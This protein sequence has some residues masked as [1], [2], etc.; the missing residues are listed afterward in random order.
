L[1]KSVDNHVELRIIRKLVDISYRVSEQ[2]AALGKTCPVWS[3]DQ[4]FTP[5]LNNA[6]PLIDDLLGNPIA[7]IHQFPNNPQ[8]DMIVHRFCQAGAIPLRSIDWKIPGGTPEWLAV[9]DSQNGRIS[10]FI[11]PDVHPDN[12]DPA[13]TLL[14]TLLASTH[15]T[16]ARTRYAIMRSIAEITIWSLNGEL[17]DK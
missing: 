6:V 9:R 3:G 8:L 11:A 2:I 10:I 16:V 1:T 12:F 17:Y 7:N 14:S 5:D 4:F 13:R 15:F